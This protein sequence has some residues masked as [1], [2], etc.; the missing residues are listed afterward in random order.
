M[1][2][3][4]RIWRSQPLRD[5][6]AEPLEV[7]VLPHPRHHRTVRTGH[8]SRRTDRHL[9]PLTNRL[10]VADQLSPGQ[11]DFGLRAAGSVVAMI[12]CVI[13]DIARHRYYGAGLATGSVKG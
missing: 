11:V 12:A 13:L 6:L 1:R 2:A 9:T 3:K 7:H 8:L 5:P 10:D 4:P